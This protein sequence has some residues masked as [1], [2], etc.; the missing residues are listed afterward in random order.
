MNDLFY[1]LKNLPKPLWGQQG[2][3]D[4]MEAVTG[5]KR[6]LIGQPIGNAQTGGE[7]WDKLISAAILAHERGQIIQFDWH[8]HH[9]DKPAY[10]SRELTPEQCSTVKHFDYLNQ[11]I[12][13]ATTE[14]FLPLK[15]MGISVL[16]RPFHEGTGAW[17]WWG[18]RGTTSKTLNSS[19]DVKNCHRMAF[20][21]L[22]SLGADNVLY[23]FNVNVH[24]ENSQKLGEPCYPGGD[25]CDIISYDNYTHDPAGSP[26]MG[27]LQDI[28]KR[29]NK[30]FALDEFGPN[31][32]TGTP[33]GFFEESAP[34]KIKTYWSDLAD[35][36]ELYDFCYVR[37]WA[38]AATGTWNDQKFAKY[39]P[40]PSVS[41]L[42]RLAYEDMHSN[43]IPRVLFAGEFQLTAFPPVKPQINFLEELKGIKI[44]VDSLIEN[45]ETLNHIPQI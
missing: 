35:Q 14:L 39:L 30:L 23:V 9:P 40:D 13:E 10:M 19:E 29:D 3:R 27:W 36:F 15:Q 42:Q 4:E 20:S 12:K 8:L 44:K 5:K 41:E 43:L 45:L 7:R 28:A 33:W 17:F 16:F 32:R 38:G 31:I 11:K 25:F 6:G 26:S 37:T 24:G 18:Y 21:T 1:I 2:P 22:Q 34:E